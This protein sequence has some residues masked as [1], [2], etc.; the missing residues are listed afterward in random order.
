M[1]FSDKLLG[2]HINNQIRYTVEKPKTIMLIDILKKKYKKTCN[3]KV[4]FL[5]KEIF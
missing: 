2:T 3:I 5:K 4:S 1:Q